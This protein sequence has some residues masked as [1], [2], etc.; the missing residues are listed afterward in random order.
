MR[1]AVYNVCVW[2]CVTPQAINMFV[3]DFAR[4][5]VWMALHWCRA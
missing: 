2:L 4:D 1:L 3:V 5:Q